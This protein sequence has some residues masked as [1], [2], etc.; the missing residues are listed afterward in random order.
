[1]M[2]ITVKN[3]CTG[4]IELSLQLIW[5]QKALLPKLG[6]GDPRQANTRAGGPGRLTSSSRWMLRRK[7]TWK[8][9]LLA[10]VD[11]YLLSVHTRLIFYLWWYSDGSAHLQGVNP[12]G[13]PQGRRFASR[14][15]QTKILGV[16]SHSGQT[17][18][19]ICS[20]QRFRHLC[21][22]HPRCRILLGTN[23]SAVRNRHCWAHSRHVKYVICR[24]FYDLDCW[25]KSDCSE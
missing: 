17:Q 5:D 14:M 2:V 3:L 12:T 23:Q 16:A 15:D 25:Y 8:S 21:W 20:V 4:T 10:C 1:M 11:L 6:T 22:S 7:C 18:I 13:C 9:L 24:H 19:K